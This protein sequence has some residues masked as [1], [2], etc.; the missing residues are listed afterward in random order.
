MG[1]GEVRD[2]SPL[3]RE[4]RQ[5]GQPVRVEAGV[6]DARSDDAALQRLPLRRLLPEVLR[7]SRRAEALHVGGLVERADLLSW[8][9]SQTR[10]RGDDRLPARPRS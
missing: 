5:L 10:V 1:T 8:P 6:V 9:V 7:A 2:C 4:E 3:R